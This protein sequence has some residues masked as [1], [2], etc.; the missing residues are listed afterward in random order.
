MI[1]HCLYLELYTSFV[2]QIKFQAHRASI[3]RMRPSSEMNVEVVVIV[4]A[5]V[6][7]LVDASYT[8]VPILGRIAA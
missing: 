5:L 6:I 7:V 3:S 2:T 4:A 1:Y 8:Q